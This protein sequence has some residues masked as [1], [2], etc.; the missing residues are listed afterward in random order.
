MIQDAASEQFTLNLHIWEYPRFTPLT[1]QCSNLPA[2]AIGMKRF[3]KIHC[4]DRYIFKLDLEHTF[5]L[6]PTEGC[7]VECFTII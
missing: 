5:S 3:L 6:A 1:N 2:E 4:I 7:T